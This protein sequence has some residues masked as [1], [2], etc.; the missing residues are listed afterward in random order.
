MK[1]KATT[2]GREIS[3]SPIHFMPFLALIVLPAKEHNGGKHG[4]LSDTRSNYHDY[5]V[6][7]L[8]LR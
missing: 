8:S 6:S 3:V 4:E 1:A 5:T 7:L 2:S